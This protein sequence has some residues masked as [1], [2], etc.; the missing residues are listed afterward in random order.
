M[1]FNSDNTGPAHPKVMEALQAAN[2]GYEPSYGADPITTRAQKAV[3][4]LFDAPEAG[5]V[6]VS[7]GTAANALALA[8]L[9]RPWQGIFCHRTAHV[10]T[11][12]CGAPEFYSGGKLVLVDGENGKIDPAR[13][14]AEIAECLDRGV[15]G[16]EPGPLTITNITEMGTVY[17][18][19]ELAELVEIAKAHGLPVHL[20]GARFANACA[21]LDCSA[22]E[23]SWKLG[24]DAVSFGGTKNGCFAV[25]AVVVFDPAK[26]AELERRRKRGGHLFSKHRFLSAQMAAYAS[27]GLWAEMA[28][29]ANARM[30]Y[31]LD[32]L[33]SVPGAQVQFGPGANLAFIDLPAAAHRR[34][35]AAGAVYTL[36]PGEALDGA[37]DDAAIRCRVVCDWGQ[38]ESNIDAL[39]AAW[40]G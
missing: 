22:A 26:L 33:A 18:L 28:Q 29:T 1:N 40:H 14:E 34:A 6:F 2:M 9:A 7:T 37:D 4:D 31:L 20:D 5:V 38:T 8:T 16:I 13:L 10:E 36:H 19:A 39:L 25:E 17:S 3:R 35:Y 11:D 32:G 23:M 27:D 30:A 12:E 21:A 24:I 15:D